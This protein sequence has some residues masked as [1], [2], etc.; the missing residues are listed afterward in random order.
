MIIFCIIFIIIILHALCNNSYK[1]V[2]YIND[3][4]DEFILNSETNIITVNNA[5][6]ETFYIFKSLSHKFTPKLSSD[7]QFQFHI[8]VGFKKFN[9]EDV[10]VYKD[11]L[12]EFI[13]EIT[14]KTK[15]L[16]YNLNLDNLLF[17]PLSKQ[18]YLIDCNPTYIDN[19]C[20]N[21]T[22]RYTVMITLL[23]LKIRAK[24]P[25]INNALSLDPECKQ[26]TEE[27]LQKNQRFPSS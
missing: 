6:R 5:S 23:N 27:H 26:L 18:I 12:D 9:D 25:F 4:G 19:Q 16:F 14:R 15:H 11:L 17:N 7:N 22:T 21:Q 10:V 8:P 2:F 3:E 1:N 20:T 24:Y 13:K